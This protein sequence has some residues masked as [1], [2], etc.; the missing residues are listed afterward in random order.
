MASVSERPKGS[1]NW[2]ALWRD[3][4]GRQRS[5]SC[6]TGVRGKKVAEQLAAKKQA[7][8]ILDQYDDRTRI[9]W[10]E[11]VVDYFDRRQTNNRE[12]SQ[13][14]A[15]EALNHFVRIVKPGVVSRIDALMIDDY[16]MKRKKEPGKR[17]I[18]VDDQ[19]RK[20]KSR[21]SPATINREL[22]SIRA[23]LRC[24]VRWG[25]LKAEPDIQFLRQDQQAPTAISAEDFARLYDNADAATLPV[26]PNGI[27]TAARWRAQ[28]MFIWFSGWRISQTLELKRSD[29]DLDA[30]TA[31]SR[32][33]ASGNKGR[34]SETIHLHSYVVEDLKEIWPSFTDQVFYWPHDM[35]TLYGQLNRIAEAA[36]VELEWGKKFH[37]IRRGFA[38]HNA[39]NL[40]T[41]ELQKLMQHQSLET[42]K[43]Y[44]AMAMRDDPTDK[45]ALPQVHREKG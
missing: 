5:K 39:A 25:Y 2:Y 19:G 44:V 32:A 20:F 8:L 14:A 45:L 17:I 15:R 1:G 42:T 31:V 13:R 24:A 35:T 18:R 11:F 23:A 6:G 9:N 10:S 21:V 36:G 7:E 22:R 16:I 4:N 28:F 37:E 26:M 41:F 30:G 29:M 38:T 27:E 3:P 12:R 33:E 34:R 40:D 43:R